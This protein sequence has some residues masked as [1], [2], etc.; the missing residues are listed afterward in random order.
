MDTISWPISAKNDDD[1]KD[2]K[3]A[4]RT[5]PLA[6]GHLI[7]PPGLLVSTGHLS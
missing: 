7:S 3:D 4:V 2:I 6:R 5:R 1:D